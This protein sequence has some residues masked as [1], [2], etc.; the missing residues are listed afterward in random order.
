M[1]GGDRGVSSLPLGRVLP[2]RGNLPGD[3]VE[4][5]AHGG[6]GATDVHHAG[7]KPRAQVDVLEG[8]DFAAA[9]PLQLLD[10]CSAAADDARRRLHRERAW[11]GGVGGKVG[12]WVKG[13]V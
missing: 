4:A 10:E 3:E 1:A 5:L 7:F 6:V 2:A 8:V 11:G 12:W 13:W 9:L